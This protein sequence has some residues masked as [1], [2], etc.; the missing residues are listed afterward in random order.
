MRS[1]H[2]RARQRID[3]EISGMSPGKPRTIKCLVTS[4]VPAVEQFA[5]AVFEIDDEF[6]GAVRQHVLAIVLGV[7]VH[8]VP[9]PINVLTQ[10]WA[11]NVPVNAHGSIIVPAS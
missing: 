4:K 6:K 11:R 10:R 3:N 2:R 1:N 9:E 8:I 5:W 7:I